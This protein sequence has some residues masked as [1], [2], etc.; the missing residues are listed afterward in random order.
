MSLSRLLLLFFTIIIIGSEL[1]AQQLS[2]PGTTS[3]VTLKASPGISYQNG[4]T[5][6]DYPPLELPD[7]Y[8]GKQLPYIV[9]NSNYPFMRPIFQQQGASC[10][11]AAGLAYNF[12]YEINRARNIPSNEASNQYPS[13]F[14]WN[15][16]NAGTYYGVGVSYFHSFEIL[17][18]LGCPNEATFGPITME[19]PYYWMSGYEKYYQAMHNRISKVNSINLSNTRG[20]L[21]LKNWLNDHLDGSLT[22][23]VANIYIGYYATNSL[24]PDSPEAGKQVVTEW[25]P[26][27]THAM[28]IVGY[29]DS[30]CYDLNSDGIFTNELDINAD[31]LIDMKDWEIGGVKLANSYGIYFAD[32]GYCYALYST[33]ATKYG[34]GGIWNNSAHVITVEPGYTPLLTL[35]ATINHNKR[36]MI[37]LR[38]GVSADTLASYPEKIMEFPVFN[39]QGGEFNMRGGYGPDD[40]DLELG[41]DITP[42]VGAMKNGNTGRFFL[43][44]DENDPMS[45]GTGSIKQFSIL[46]YSENSP[47]EF[48]CPDT[49]FQL[50]GNGSTILYVNIH[51]QLADITI[52]PESMP[53][54][55]AGSPVSVQLSATDAQL[56]LKWSIK[57][58]YSRLVGSTAF[59]HGGGSELPISTA[60]EGISMLI[61]PFSFPFYGKTYDTLII[62]TDGYLLFEAMNAPYPYLQ[63][64]ALYLSQIK[65]IGVFMNQHQQISLPEHGVWVN[66]DN[67]KVI[68][69]WVLGSELTP[70]QSNSFSITLYPD[71]KIEQ[72][73]G[74]LNALL[75][76]PGV[77]GISDG[78]GTNFQVQTWNK[79][80]PAGLISFYPQQLP[81]GTEISEAGLIS[82]QTI[83]GDF[84]ADFTV[85]LTDGRHIQKEKKYSL[86]NGPYVEVEISSGDDQMIEAGEEAE[87][88][89]RLTNN[90]SG[91]YDNIQMVLRTV[92]P[93]IQLTDSIVT[94]N[95]LA[96]G[97]TSSLEQAFSFIVSD[98]ISRNYEIAFLLQINWDGH[99]VQ[100]FLNYTAFKL[101]YSIS[102]PLIIDQQ[103][104]QPDPGESCRLIF[105]LSN[106]G[107]K[108]VPDFKGL[109]SSS[110]PFISLSP[111][112]GNPFLKLNNNSYDQAEWEL[113]I[114]PNTPQGHTA[115]LQMMAISDQYDTLQE[116]FNVTIGDTKILIIDLDRNHN[117]AVHIASSIS[118]LGI[119]PG[120][121]TSIDSNIFSFSQLF[122]CLG[123]KP[124]MHLLLSGENEL[125]NHYLEQGGNV[126]LESGV[127][128]GTSISYSAI[129]K[130]RVSG[131]TQAWTQRPDTLV[132]LPSTIMDGLQYHY[133]GDSLMIY[134]LI[135]EE[136][137]I[138]LFHDKNTG[139]IFTVANDSNTFRTIA[140]SVEFGGIFPYAE[141]T[142][143]LIMKE[144]LSFL[145]ANPEALAAN[146]NASNYSS[147]PGLDIHFEPFCAGEPL[148]YHWEFEEGDPAE[149]FQ[150]APEC[151]W[152]DPGF[153]SVSL[154]VT[155]H[156][157]TNT[158]L[159]DHLIEI[160]NCNDTQ[161]KVNIW[162]GILYPNP[163]SGS[164]YLKFYSPRQEMIKFCIH[165]ISGKLIKCE[166]RNISNGYIMESIDI[167]GLS[168]GIYLLIINR[169]SGKELMRLTVR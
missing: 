87:V 95:S 37:R 79:N 22:G 154:T 63:D 9:D 66:S 18:Q 96:A 91:V 68:I 84:T 152:S 150:S 116:N 109:L 149:S 20:L 75:E 137:A 118:K 16:M 134:N 130:F 27:A 83:T 89:L 36:G 122:V 114:N 115:T 67:G 129:E 57:R 120:I 17:R 78:D 100:K 138:A 41:L 159:K 98:T 35:K 111:P 11:Q 69:T 10:G 101:K 13:H 56:P 71:G 90:S 110:D 85:V 107:K 104:N 125:L 135:P 61:L 142:R 23:G 132:G 167:K 88:S 126:Y 139:H 50:M 44:V 82:T 38:V 58:E 5:D 169:H 59:I 52:L 160:L 143:E 31:G 157:G 8:I 73:F 29:H 70:D 14:T 42:L 164:V 48:T 1:L 54:A 43:L 49:P 25:D 94:L 45:S 55:V 74:D 46:S 102:G 12:C 4:L 7:H 72:S 136:P 93:V 15:F 121:Q 148:T 141:T 155:D 30:I 34:Y 28:T 168:P 127:M 128:F 40:K 33:L 146:F 158:L 26:I 140:S 3:G 144:Y 165:D 62:H 108:P 6:P 60:Q 77:S 112:I 53:T 106:G 24:P 131:N 161:E 145:G 103:N 76:N 113:S 166:E 86:S 92:S 124:F 163:A 97:S 162:D 119:V 105:R 153:Y 32:S 65:G 51:E 21:T 2:L 99:H 19:N 81:E 133:K 64:E 123:V 80:T 117:S 151:R 156:N 39:F 147:C 47:K